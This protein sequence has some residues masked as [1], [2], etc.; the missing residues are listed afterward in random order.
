M[1]KHQELEKL[2][3]SG[4]GKCDPVMLENGRRWHGV[5][6]IVRRIQT[7][8]ENGTYFLGGRW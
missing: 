4:E 5:G 2:L 1:S 3:W 6:Y 7:D 8:R